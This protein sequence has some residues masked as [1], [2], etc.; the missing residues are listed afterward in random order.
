M[1]TTSTSDGSPTAAWR[2]SVPCRR[3]RDDDPL[4]AVAM[5]TDEGYT[6][7]FSRHG[8][9]VLYRYKELEEGQDL[10]VTE[11]RVLRDLRLSKMFLAEQLEGAEVEAIGLLAPPEQAQAWHGWLEATF[12]RPILDVDAY[13][14]GVQQELPIGVVWNH[15]APLLGAVRQEVA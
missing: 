14:L 6:I 10:G 7:L 9:P 4:R 3:R 8:L 5:V 2:C 12:D 1:S 13:R 15:V 11:R